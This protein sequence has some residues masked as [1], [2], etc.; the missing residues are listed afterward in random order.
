MS[1][2]P[3]REMVRLDLGFGT[4]DLG[5][6]EC[7]E[8]AGF[9]RRRGEQPG[10][11]G[12]LAAAGRLEALLQDEAAPTPGPVTEA[13]L[14]ALADAAW[15][16]LRQVGAAGLPPRVLVLLDGLRARHAHD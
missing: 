7:G 1:L 13:E 8:L 9:L 10:D 6:G 15:Q 12:A 5:R 16:W 4:Y 3:D 14:D 11:D 2:L